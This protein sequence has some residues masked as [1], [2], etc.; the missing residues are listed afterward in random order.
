[1]YKFFFF[2]IVAAI[3]VLVVPACKKNIN[4]AEQPEE[5]LRISTDASALNYTAGPGTDFNLTI[6][7]VIP[8]AGVK[9]EFIVKGEI[10]NLSYFVGPSTETVNKI[11]RIFINNLPKQ[12]ICICTITVT[13]KSKSTNF[14]TTSF[15]VAYK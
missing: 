8:K 5:Q 14:A 12:K 9:I 6:E 15:R 7:S 4:T 1:M 2:T 13:S 11:T 3:T 10:D